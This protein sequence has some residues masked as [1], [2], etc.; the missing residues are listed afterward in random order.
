MSSHQ[1]GS[2]GSLMIE[3]RFPEKT[4]AGLIARGHDVRVLEAYATK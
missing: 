2:D 3:N 1:G 4:I